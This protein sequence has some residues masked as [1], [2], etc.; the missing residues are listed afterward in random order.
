MSDLINEDLKHARSLGLYVH[1]DI[2]PGYCFYQD[3][4][5]AIFFT[6]GVSHSYHLFR[7]V[8]HHNPWFLIQLPWYYGEELFRKS[9]DFIQD[10]FGIDRRRLVILANA[11]EET[12]AAKNQGMIF[13][14]LIPHNCWLDFN[15]IK[16]DASVRKDFDLVINCRPENW[17]RPYLAGDVSNLAIIKGANHRP[18][19]YFDLAKLNPRYINQD[20][21]SLE[22]VVG[23]LN[24]TRCGG[25]FSEVEGG[26]YSSSEY[27]MAGLPVVSTPSKGGRDEW[28]TDYNSI[29]VDPDPQS[30]REAVAE[31]CGKLSEGSLKPETI[32]SHHREMSIGFRADFVQLL[33][34]LLEGRADGQ[35]IFESQY[36]HKMVRYSKAA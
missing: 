33:N 13:S 5:I 22:G 18:E 8:K 26:C 34:E 4:A 2:N 15:L 11:S 30:V 19:D 6:E 12:E 28:Y 7:T 35:Q 16:P 36:Q 17:K 27:L 32:A 24:R 29:I 1:E 20:R 31:L 10:R 25:I 9:A 23:I 21:L 14:R 3:D